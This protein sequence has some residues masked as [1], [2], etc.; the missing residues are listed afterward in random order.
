[1]KHTCGGILGGWVWRDKLLQVN[2][3]T[4]ITAI[5]I[6]ITIHTSIIT[7]SIQTSSKYHA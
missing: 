6:A 4:S 7:T 5:T 2:T 3:P 1:M